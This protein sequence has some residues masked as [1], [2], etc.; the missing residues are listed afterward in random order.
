MNNTPPASGVSNDLGLALS[1]TVPSTTLTANGTGTYLWS[2]G[3]TTQSITVSTAGTFN[4]TVT[5]AN[6][7]TNTGTATTTLDNTPPASGV[8]NDLGLA[9]AVQYQV[10]P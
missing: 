4:V 5:G 8:S 3:A 1:C 2:T 9:L 10:Q 6:G 7:C